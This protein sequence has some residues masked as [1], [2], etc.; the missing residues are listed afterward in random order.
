MILPSPKAVIFDWDNTLVDTWPIIAKAIN[1]TFREWHMPEWTL[2]DVKARVRKSMR[3]SFPDIFG[4]DKWQA[5]GEFYQAQYRAIHLEALEALPQAAELLAQIKGKGLFS[6]VVSNK[7]GPN[8]RKEVEHLGWMKF[9][10]T[11]VGSDDAPRDKPHVDPV[12]L[13]FEK[14]HLKP[15]RDVWF[16]GD[17][18]IDLECAHATGCIAILYGEAARHHSGYSKTH[19]NGFHYDAHVHDHGEAMK[20]LATY[21]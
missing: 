12:L 3:D 11:I 2:D 20:L 8:L 1:A 16:I 21:A 18:E 13:A 9:F 15:G 14:S 4:K 7:K 6:V 10:D 17:S 19:Y 5:A